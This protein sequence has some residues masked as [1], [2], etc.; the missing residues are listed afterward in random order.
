MARGICVQIGK[1]IRFLRIRKGWTQ[2]ILADHAGLT[3]EHLSE[4]ENGH[5]E[6]GIMAL[7]RIIR[8]MDVTWV[9]FFED[10]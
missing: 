9:K 10:F 4:L 2:T 7:D 8:A 1:R 3:R 6:I 5:K